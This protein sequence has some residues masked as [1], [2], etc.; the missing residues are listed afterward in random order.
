MIA[1]LYDVRRYRDFLAN[2]IEKGD[3]VIEIGPH[4][5]KAVRLYMDR[6]ALA[7]VVDKGAQ[8]EAEMSKLEERHRNLRFIRGDARRFETVGKVKEITKRCDVLAVDLGGGRF[9]DTVFKVWALWS[10]VFQPRHSVIRNRGIAEFLQKAKI[11]DDS[12]VRGFPEDG[13]LSTWGR[14]TPSKL[15]EQMGE[16][17]FWID[18]DKPWKRGGN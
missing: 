2:K 13:W 16:F 8:A 1:I 7:V 6:T 12:L 10:G 17:G 14:A 3:T 5:G 9:P 4:L 11:A 15:Q 18:L